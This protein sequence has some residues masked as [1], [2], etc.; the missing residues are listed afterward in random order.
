MASKFFI[1]PLTPEEKQKLRLQFAG[2]PAPAVNSMG[3]GVNNRGLSPADLVALHVQEVECLQAT[4]ERLEYEYTRQQRII[5]G[6]GRLLDESADT[7]N[8]RWDGA[9]Y[10]LTDLGWN[11]LVDSVPCPSLEYI[12]LEEEAAMQAEIAADE[13]ALT[14]Y[15]QAA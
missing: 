3:A 7:L 8:E 15:F 10:T 13:Q 2:L 5:E 6:M 4:I 14:V 12:D 1:R 9:L 11:E